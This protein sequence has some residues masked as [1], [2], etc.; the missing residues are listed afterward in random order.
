[1]TEEI[2]ETEPAASPE[3]AEVVVDAP[4]ADIESVTEEI[5]ETEPAISPEDSSNESTEVRDEKEETEE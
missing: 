5:V 2:S 1:M 3:E 4:I